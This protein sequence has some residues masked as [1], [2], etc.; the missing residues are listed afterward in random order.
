MRSAGDPDADTLQ[1]WLVQGAPLGM[2]RRIETTRVFPPADKPHKEDHSPAQG[3]AEQLTG[4]WGHYRS[5]LENTEDAHK[6]FERYPAA[7]IA[8][9]VDETTLERL[10]PKGHVNTLGLIVKESPEK[11]KVRLVVDMRRSRATA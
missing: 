6:E 3:V 9:D 4:E 11:R 10:F 8:V 2:D 7:Q 5:V 1:D